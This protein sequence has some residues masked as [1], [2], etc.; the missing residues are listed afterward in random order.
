MIVGMIE[1]DRSRHRPTINRNVHLGRRTGASLLPGDGSFRKVRPPFPMPNQAPAV[2][3]SKIQMGTDNWAAVVTSLE[4]C[5]CA[6]QR[7]PYGRASESTTLK[8]R[9]PVGLSCLGTRIT[10]SRERDALDGPGILL[11]PRARQTRASQ[12]VHVDSFHRGAQTFDRP[13]AA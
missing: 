10:L 4:T 9:F 2:I 3:S 1:V 6:K 13:C 7:P 12:M 11:L 8:D 5:G